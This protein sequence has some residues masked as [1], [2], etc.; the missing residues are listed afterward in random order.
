M[1]ISDFTMKTLFP[2]AF[3]VQKYNT[4]LMCCTAILSAFHAPLLAQN[5]NEATMATPKPTKSIAQYYREG[6]DAFRNGRWQTAKEA[7]NQVVMQAPESLLASE[8]SFFAA[9]ATLRNGD[10]NWLQELSDWR[11]QTQS[12]VFKFRSEFKFHSEEQNTTEA[13]EPSPDETLRKQLPQKTVLFAIERLEKWLPES[14]LEEAKEL[15]RQGQW[16]WALHA[17]SSAQATE[18]ATY[19]ATSRASVPENIPMT[20]AEMWI[21]R[22]QL[23]CQVHLQQWDAAESTFHDLEKSISSY[24]TQ[25]DPPT[26]IPQVLLRRSE[27][28]I[29]Q[30]DWK[31]AESTVCDI[32]AHFPECNER[33][34]VDYVF[35]RCLVF[36]A[37]FDEARQ[38]F[39]SIVHRLPTPPAEL[40]AKAWWATAESYVMQRRFQEACVGYE[41]VLSLDVDTRWK[42]VV[43]KQLEACRRAANLNA[44]SAGAQPSKSSV[45]PVQSTQRPTNSLR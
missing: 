31:L 44:Q 33:G 23:E 30:G 43:E 28:A 24:L 40:L 9:L 6:T 36:N 7:L 3:L 20:D 39:E 41:N 38:V 5:A 16:R 4:H 21:L 26:W 19:R 27:I 15:I 37:R 2:S 35:A 32:R 12:T 11:C 45:P 25:P 18:R 14:D 34:Y 29:V 13:T 10:E 42:Q 8:A 22:N 1:L 17:L